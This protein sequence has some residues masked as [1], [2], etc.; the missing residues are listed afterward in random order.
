MLSD[1]TG[2][3]PRA[4]LRNV[5]THTI[6]QVLLVGILGEDRLTCINGETLGFSFCETSTV[7]GIVVVSIA[8]VLFFVLCVVLLNNEAAQV[9]AVW[10]FP[11]TNYRTRAVVGLVLCVLIPIAFLAWR[12]Y[13]VAEI[14]RL[15]DQ[16]P[17]ATDEK[18]G[19][20]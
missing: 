14:T 17:P 15:A 19:Q 13:I 11:G 16:F 5:H 12:M 18:P 9:M 7:M 3:T 2:L 4:T 1:L 6:V 20:A 8:T 10:T